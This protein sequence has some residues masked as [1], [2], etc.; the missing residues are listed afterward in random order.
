MMSGMQLK[1]NVQN[2]V[3]MIIDILNKRHEKKEVIDLFK[4]SICYNDKIEADYISRDE[5]CLNE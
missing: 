5:D 4:K 1:K 2:E 3:Q